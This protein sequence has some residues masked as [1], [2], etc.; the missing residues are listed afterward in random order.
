MPR[1]SLRRAAILSLVAVSLVGT[2]GCIGS[3]QL[4]RKLYTFNT[5]ASPDKW[6][7]EL[8]FLGLNVVPVYGLAI[9]ADA[10]FANAVEFWTGTNPVVSARTVR[11][12]GTAL[13]QTGSTTS[14]GKTMVIEEI[15]DGVTLSSTT[16]TLREGSETLTVETRFKDGRTV[17][18]TLSRQFPPTN[19]NAA[20]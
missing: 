2:T 1:V 11:S 13:V 19:W 18:K 14:E 3:F 15:K 10:L 5:S 16:M 4:T 9:A 8:V 12:D 6:V 20:Q 7:Q 17:S